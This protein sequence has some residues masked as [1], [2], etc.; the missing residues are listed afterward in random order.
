MST[1]G[2]GRKQQ[3]R[4]RLLK[5]ADMRERRKKQQGLYVYAMFSRG[6]LFGG[7][8]LLLQRWLTADAFVKRLLFRRRTKRARSPAVSLQFAAYNACPAWNN[9]FHSL[10]STR[11]EAQ[12]AF[13]HCVSG[14]INRERDVMSFS[15]YIFRILLDSAKQEMAQ[16]NYIVMKS[17]KFHMFKSSQL[18]VSLKRSWTFFDGTKYHFQTYF[19]IGC[20]NKN[21]C[22]CNICKQLWLF[23]S[24][25]FIDILLKSLNFRF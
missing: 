22:I 18:F 25:K 3:R 2:P 5:T 17:F 10:A 1:G 12:A 23:R 13:C 7:A 15:N 20:W 6:I 19:I 14:L 16:S 24:Y 9:E 21:H 8:P 11:N 4:V